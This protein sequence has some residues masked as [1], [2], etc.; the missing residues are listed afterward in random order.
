MDDFNERK[1]EYF[2]KLRE[3]VDI[4]SSLMQSEGNIKS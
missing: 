3:D 1:E 4:I 2:K